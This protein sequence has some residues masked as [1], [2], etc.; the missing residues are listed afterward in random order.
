MSLVSR[1]QEISEVWT[2]VGTPGCWTLAREHQILRCPPLAALCFCFRHAGF[3]KGTALSFFLLRKS[4]HHLACWMTARAT[5]KRC[6]SSKSR[7]PKLGVY[8]RGHTRR[9]LMLFP[10]PQ[11][12]HRFNTQHTPEN[13]GNKTKKAGIIQLWYESELGQELFV[14]VVLNLYG[15][16]QEQDIHNS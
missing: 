5:M 15:F 12:K 3:R 2:R 4:T 1:N 9:V 14:Q 8:P 10:S 11:F 16:Q 13:G 6:I 7:V